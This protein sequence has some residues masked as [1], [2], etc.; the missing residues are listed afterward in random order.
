MAPI[1]LALRNCSLSLNNPCAVAEQQTIFSWTKVNPAWC[2]SSP[3][4]ERHWKICGSANLF[5]KKVFYFINMVFMYDAINLWAHTWPRYTKVATE[6]TLFFALRWK[7]WC[8]L[9]FDR[10]LL[11]CIERF[12]INFETVFEKLLECIS[13]SRVLR[14]SIASK[15]LNLK[16]FIIKRQCCS[17]RYIDLEKYISDGQYLWVHLTYACKL[18]W[19]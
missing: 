17:M 16:T 9:K 14:F 8:L 15:Q 7:D 10:F 3:H 4:S 13:S 12:I 19:F 6:G 1:H 2:S 18:L 5:K 11:H